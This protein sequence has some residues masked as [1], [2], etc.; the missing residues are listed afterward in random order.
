VFDLH[1]TLARV[2][3][4]AVDF[5]DGCLIYDFRTGRLGVVDLD[6][7]RDGPFKNEMGRLFGSSRFMAPEE[8]ELGARIDRRTN[9]FVLGRAALVFLSD[10]TLIPGAFR[11]SPALFEVVTRACEPEPSRRFESVGMFYR[12]WLAARMAFQEGT[13]VD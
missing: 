9:V 7:Y 12:A 1:D 5:Y 13:D 10:G 11:G 2:G 6:M 8:F 3:W 4:I